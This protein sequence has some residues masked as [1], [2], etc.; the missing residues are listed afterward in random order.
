MREG[1]KY[2]STDEE[3]VRHVKVELERMD[4]NR[5]RDKLFSLLL[6]YHNFLLPVLSALSLLFDKFNRE[7]RTWGRTI[8]DSVVAR[9]LHG[10]HKFRS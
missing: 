9:R 1:E 7:R 2:D 8:F 4:R 3:R 6:H 5:Q 10:P